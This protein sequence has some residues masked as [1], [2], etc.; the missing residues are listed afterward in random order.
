MSKIWIGLV[1]ACGVAAGFVFA[2]QPGAAAEAVS[3]STATAA[4]DSSS[5]PVAGDGSLTFGSPPLVG[6]DKP[7]AKPP[8]ETLT[9]LKSGPDHVR[10]VYRLKNAPSGN[11]NVTLR[12]LFRLEGRFDMSAATPAKPPAG[13][14]VA[15]V[16]DP[17]TNS[18]VISGRPEAVNEVRTLL[19]KLD[20]PAAMVLMEM[21]NGRSADQRGQARRGSQA[22]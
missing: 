2:C 14:S 4:K 9:V 21:E 1:A 18:L 19:D 3:G 12:E 8:E 11:V 16:A 15:I 17:I 13:S 22:Q 10:I 7:A 6:R 5:P 20:Q